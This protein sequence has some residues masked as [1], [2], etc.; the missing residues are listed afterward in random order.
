ME[1]IVTTVV[2]NKLEDKKYCMKYQ[3]L[4]EKFLSFEAMSDEDFK[5]NFNEALHLVC[6]VSY[7]KDTPS[8]ILLSNVGLIHEMVHYLN[9]E[10]IPEVNFQRIRNQFNIW[11]KLA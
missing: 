9:K 4:K 11:V 7:I 10:T 8:Y 3:D 5:K 1:Y 6:V 2:D